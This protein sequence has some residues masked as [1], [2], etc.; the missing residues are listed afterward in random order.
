MDN[1]QFPGPGQRETPDLVSRLSQNP[2]T[3]GC[4]KSAQPQDSKKKTRRTSSSPRSR[5]ARDEE[6]RFEVLAN[7]ENLLHEVV[8]KWDNL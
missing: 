3:S 1:L 5:A 2:T 7:T 6:T 4:G 8:A